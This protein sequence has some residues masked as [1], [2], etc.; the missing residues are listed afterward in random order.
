MLKRLHQAPAI[1]NERLA[2]AETNIPTVIPYA[3][4][5]F[6]DGLRA[7]AVT[8]VVASHVGIPGFRGGFIGVD[9]FFV[10]SGFLIIGQILHELKN[11]A[12]SFA[13]FWAKR[14]L[15]IIPPFVGN[16]AGVLFDSTV[17]FCDAEPVQ[18]IWQ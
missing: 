1:Q 5:P 9:I 14:T 12:F 16:A 6:I 4:R 2:H 13:N 8:A 17:C 3:Y 18:G 7:I 10:I 11:E 15:R